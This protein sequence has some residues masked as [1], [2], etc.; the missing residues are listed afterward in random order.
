MRVKTMSHVILL[1]GLIV[2]PCLAT[3]AEPTF[4]EGMVHDQ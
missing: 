4:K 1:L 3:A 2:A